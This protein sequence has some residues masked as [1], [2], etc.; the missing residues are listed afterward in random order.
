MAGCAHKPAPAPVE[1]VAPDPYGY[2]KVSAVCTVGPMQNGPAGRVAT[3]SVR[4]DDGL[5]AVPVSQPDGTAYASFL[6]T[7]PPAH[8]KTFI[9]NYNNQTL[10]GYTPTTAYA[11]PDSFTVSLVPVGGGPRSLLRVDAV[12]DAT[13]VMRPV[14]PVAAAA[15]PPSSEGHKTVRHHVV[16]K[17]PASGN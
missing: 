6:L 15:P 17:K 3:M 5:C 2:E 8:G 4:S 14:A 10:I 16:R 13:G 11:G 7:T 1:A 9:H 12:V